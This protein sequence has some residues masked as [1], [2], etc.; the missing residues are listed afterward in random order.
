MVRHMNKLQI[1]LDELVTLIDLNVENLKEMYPALE[2]NKETIKTVIIE[3]K[4]KFVKTLVKG[5]KEF[6]KEVGQVKAQ[7]EKLYL[8]YMI[9]MD[10]H[11]K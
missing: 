4:D 7:G 8:D 6:E 3:E 1:S 2:S 10:F 5:E 9:H 11:Q